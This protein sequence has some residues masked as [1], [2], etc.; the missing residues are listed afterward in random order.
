[1]EA[2]VALPANCLSG[3]PVDE[4]AQK[5]CRKY[6]LDPYI[7]TYMHGKCT[8]HIILGLLPFEIS[9]HGIDRMENI[10]TITHSASMSC[11]SRFHTPTRGA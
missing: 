4:L 3:R 1:M 11:A 2:Y 7:L 8:K 6:I 9:Q 10:G 5:F